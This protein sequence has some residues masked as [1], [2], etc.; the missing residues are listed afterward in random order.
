ML[1]S[2]VFKF[3]YFAVLLIATMLMPDNVFSTT[4][5]ENGWLDKQVTMQFQSEPLS[6]VL[7][8]I[9]QQTGISIIYNLELANEKVNINYKDIKASDA[10]TRLFKGKNI[11]IQ[12]NNQENIIIVKTFGAKNFISSS[13]IKGQE[14]SSQMTLA[15]LEDL[16]SQQYKEY[17]ERISDDNE[18]IMGGMTRAAIRAMQKKQ[19]Q[20]YEDR[21]DNDDVEV[22]GTTFGKL[23]TMHEQ[24]YTE[25][26]EQISNANEVLIGNIT[27]GE[28]G[29][30]QEKQSNLYKERLANDEILIGNK[31]SREL[32][33]LHRQQYREY[34]ESQK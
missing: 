29:V 26:Q 4:A 9:T 5:K 10:I 24:Q 8:E 23:R 12:I 34:L 15:Q 7:A 27:R 22:F 31:T 17:K 33:T 14:S 20:Q 6:N 2:L 3:G 16:H 18:V 28:L 25:Y 32:D 1:N 11:V 30:M 19:S 21:I 13:P